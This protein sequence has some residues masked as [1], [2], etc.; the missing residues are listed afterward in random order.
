MILLQ[1]LFDT[2]S[3]NLWIPSKNCNDYNI[4]CSLNNKYDNSKSSTYKKNGTVITFAYGS[5]I[6]TGVMSTDIVTIGLAIIKDQTFGE[7]TSEYFADFEGE[8]VVEYDGILGLGLGALASD[9]MTTVFENMVKQKLV[10][11]PVFSFYL[12]RDT[13]ES[14]GGEIIFGGSDPAHYRGNFT[15]VPIDKSGYWKFVMDEISI[16]Q[17]NINYCDD[18]CQAIADTGTTSIIGPFYQIEDINYRIGATSLGGGIY[19]VDCESINR[20]PV[21]NFYI[22]GK[23]FK[24]TGNQYVRK[25]PDK[26]RTLCL[27]GFIWKDYPF[28]ILGDLFIGPYYTEFD[29]GNRRIG[30]AE[31]V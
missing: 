31:A 9:G 27:S 2:G 1:V 16:G 28:W 3:S 30:F 5:G 15:Y 21:I 18:N 26:G 4:A 8:I 19:S 22:G 14:S 7:E 23:G 11:N 10:K 6:V 20:L 24:L 25:I 13:T 29:Y 12:N 17:Q